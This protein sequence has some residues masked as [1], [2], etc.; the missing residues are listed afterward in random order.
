MRRSCPV[1]HRL[2]VEEGVAEVAAHHLPGIAGELDPARLVEAE[3]LAD[4]LDVLGRRGVVADEDLHRVARRELDDGEAQHQ[5]ADEERAEAHEPPAN[6]R[7][8]G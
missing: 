5:H 1:E 7:E 2:V 3:A 8:H 4:L 6:E